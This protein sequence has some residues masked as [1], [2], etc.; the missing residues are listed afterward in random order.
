MILMFS[1]TIFFIPVADLSS[2]LENTATCLLA[3]MAFQATVKDML[4][5]VA[6]Q[7]ALDRYVVCVYSIIL[8]HGIEHALMFFCT[9]EET[10]HW[11]E[12]SADFFHGLIDYHAIQGEDILAAEAI[13]VQVEIVI[14]ILAHIYYV[15]HLLALRKIGQDLRLTFSDECNGVSIVKG[16]PAFGRSKSTT[17]RT[18]G[19]WHIQRSNNSLAE[20]AKASLAGLRHGS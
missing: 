3:M 1:F 16:P 14:L 12:R 5:A 13:M 20:T 7:T 10:S 4:P 8:F 9:A 2:R 19:A 17:T 18:F 15:Y 11:S 6:Y